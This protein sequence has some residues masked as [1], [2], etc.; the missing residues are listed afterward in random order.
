M[1]NFTEGRGNLAGRCVVLED[2]IPVNFFKL[3]MIAGLKKYTTGKI[4]VKFVSKNY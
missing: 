1:L 3:V 4:L 2:L